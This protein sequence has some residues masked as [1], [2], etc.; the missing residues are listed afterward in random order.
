MVGGVAS[1]ED[2]LLAASN[3][4]EVKPS[5]SGAIVLQI[6]SVVVFKFSSHCFGLFIR[7][8]FLVTAK[9][10]KEINNT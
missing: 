7:L 6:L 4:E 10:M 8:A 9:K 1:Q 3:E 5:E 2:S